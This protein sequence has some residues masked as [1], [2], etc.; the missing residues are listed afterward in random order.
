MLK[1]LL[2]VLLCVGS[3]CFADVYDDRLQLHYQNEEA[4]ELAQIRNDNLKAEAAF[5]SRLLA[6]GNA[7]RGFASSPDCYSL[8][9]DGKDSYGGATRQACVRGFCVNVRVPYHDWNGDSISR[10]M[11]YPD[12][13]ARVCKIT[14]NDGLAC[15]YSIGGGPR[16][17]DAN[18]NSTTGQGRVRRRH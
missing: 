4:K 10:R 2:A 11:Q 3:V 16:C 8:F 14:L 7:H 1:T 6:F 9:M 5:L 13:I 17:L 18:G 15:E 12:T